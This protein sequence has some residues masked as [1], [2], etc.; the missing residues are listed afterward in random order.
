[1]AMENPND[2]NRSIQDERVSKV[3]MNYVNEN[4]R[5]LNDNNEMIVEWIKHK[6]KKL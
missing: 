1:M 3:K 6:A 4:L 2:A 5:W